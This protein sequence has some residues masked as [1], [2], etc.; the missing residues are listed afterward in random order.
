MLILQVNSLVILCI[1][2]ATE[3]LQVYSKY[4]CF[5]DLLPKKKLYCVIMGECCVM[6]LSVGWIFLRYLKT[7]MIVH[8]S[9]S[10]L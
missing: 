7:L 4:F 1:L 10:H 8:N 3:L 6:W 2:S 5:W 9:V